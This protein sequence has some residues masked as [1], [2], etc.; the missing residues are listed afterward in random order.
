MKQWRGRAD[1]RNNK[2]RRRAERD[3]AT[4]K[5]PP[6]G[7][8]GK[9]IKEIS[10]IQRSEANRYDFKVHDTELFLKSVLSDNIIE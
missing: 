9:F 7:T 2:D 1:H 6:R 4:Y 3:I 10:F 8:A 5:R